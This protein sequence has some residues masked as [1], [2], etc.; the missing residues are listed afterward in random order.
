MLEVS[1]LPP[2]LVDLLAAT[3]LLQVAAGVAFLIG[4]Y[5][6]LRRM[7]RWLKRAAAAITTLSATI[8]SVHGLTDFINRTDTTLERQDK[9]INEIHHESM[10]NNE[11]SMKDAIVRTELGQKAGVLQARAL[12]DAV[13]RLR[14][15]LK[16]PPDQPKE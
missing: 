13:E 9:L 10:Y 2:W 7:W 11:T 6:L 12:A 15:D 3:T 4:A 16:L 5:F 1:V 8:D 14:A